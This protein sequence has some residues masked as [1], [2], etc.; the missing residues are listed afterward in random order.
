VSEKKRRRKLTIQFFDNFTR[1]ML[2]T[3]IHISPPMTDK[4]W[5][6]AM[7]IRL[8]EASRESNFFC[9]KINTARS[10]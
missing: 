10:K 6:K 1:E 7:L 3:D 2:A 4:E 9:Y 5:D 8:N